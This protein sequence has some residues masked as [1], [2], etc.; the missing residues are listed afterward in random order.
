[1]SAGI[2]EVLAATRPGFGLIGAAYLAPEVYE[3]DLNL[4]AGRWSYAGHVSEVAEPGD[5]ITAALGEESAI[6]VRGSDG[7]LRA[8]ANVCRH[9]GSRICSAPSGHASV[10]TCPYH[11]WTYHLD[12]RLR[13]AR[14]MPAGFDGALHGLKALPLAEVGGLIFIAFTEQPPRLDAVAP[15]LKAMTTRYDWNGARIAAR[16]S[17]EV[18]ANWKLVLENYHECYHCGP[19]HPEF[20]ALHALAQP[21]ARTLSGTADPL[22][23]LADFEAWGPLADGSE[24]ARVMRS[25]LL[26]GCETGSRNGKRLA[27]PMGEGGM[28]APGLCVFAELGFLTA[29]LAYPDHGVIYRFFPLGVR[30]TGMEVI[31]LVA[32]AAREGADYD[33]EALTWL[34]DV[35]SQADKAIIERNQAG[36]ASRAYEPG[37]F[38]LMEP[39][40]RQY[41]ERY[42]AE[43]DRLTKGVRS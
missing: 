14:E 7:V 2:S 13:A 24:V 19:A 28:S 43:L 8:L 6:I 18:A 38:S 3:A 17:Y 10:L 15:A 36:V 35:T 30:R 12:G 32:G 16:R 33:L 25:G 37:P 26:P 41:V 42:A 4:L 9:R 29:F 31:W 21:R 40:T 34:W 11:A 39:G 5:W 20:S 1:V 27:P 23:G 22:T